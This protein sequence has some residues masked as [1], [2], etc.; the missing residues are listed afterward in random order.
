MLV[1]QRTIRSSLVFALVAAA[2]FCCGCDI[3]VFTPKQRVQ[4]HMKEFAEAIS[5]NDAR[6]AASFCDGNMFWET[7]N[8]KK[9][10]QAAVSGFLE[11]FR[12]MDRKV[13]KLDGVYIYVK[14]M[15]QKDPTKMLADVKFEVHLVLNAATLSFAKRNWTAKM[16]WV[17]EGM[18]TWKCVG[19]RELTGRDMAGHN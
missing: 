16:Y 5:A 13:D 2:V 7:P 4:R 8:T 9:K 12:Q 18:K 1:L 19:I 3:F 6:K 17:K 14:S 15:E 11:S 10:G